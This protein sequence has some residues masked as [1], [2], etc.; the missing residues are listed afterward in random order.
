[1]RQEQGSFHVFLQVLSA[2]IYVLSLFSLRQQLFLLLF[3]L[4]RS[5]TGQRSATVA[6]T[7][8]RGLDTARTCVVAGL[9]RTQRGRRDYPAQG[10]LEGHHDLLPGS[11]PNKRGPSRQVAIAILIS[12]PMAQMKP[13]S[14]RAIAATTTVGFLP[15]ATMER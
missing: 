14:S 6:Q 2:G 8:I 9:P 7:S 10:A 4:I 15:L 11:P 13:A 3:V 5:G 12:C 1:V